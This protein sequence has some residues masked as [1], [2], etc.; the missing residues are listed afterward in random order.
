M[1]LGLI[2]ETNDPGAIW[3]GF[4]LGNTALAAGH[5]VT[6]YL[7]GD[8]VEAPDQPAGDD[9]NPHGVMRKFL[10]EGGELLACDR[11]LDHRDLDGD[12]LRP[13][14]GMDE[15]LSLIEDADETVTIG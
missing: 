6:A 4:R 8:G 3:N 9:V 13:R 12:E 1:Q 10:L 11:C 15:L 2:V 14:A 5:D 7:L